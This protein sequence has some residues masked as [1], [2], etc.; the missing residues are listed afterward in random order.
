MSNGQPEQPTQRGVP[1]DSRDAKQ[2]LVSGTGGPEALRVTRQ[3]PIGDHAGHAVVANN[4]IG[5]N[6]IDV[7]HRNGFYPLPTPFVPGVEGAG[8]IESAQNLQSDQ[9]V[10]DR[11]GYI[12]MFGAYAS[13]VS[14]PTDRLIPLP[15]D[16][17]DLNAAACLLQGITTYAML[18]DVYHVQPGETILVHAAAGG[19]G[20]LMCQWASAVGATVI[21]TVSSPE[22]ATI[23][24]AN[25]C[26]YPLLNTSPQWPEEVRDLTNGRGVPVVYDSIGR[27]TFT[28]SLDCLSLRGLLVSLGQSSGPPDP[29]DVPSLGGRGSLSI[30]RPSV[31]HFVPD[32]VALLRAAEAVFA[33]IRQGRLR[34]EAKHLFPL[35]HA[36]EAHTELEARRTTGPL[37]LIP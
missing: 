2:V 20:L 13:R 12:G 25:G 21:G 26:T 4:A 31:F 5:V 11:V 37:V 16:I 17:S 28:G 32:R 15:A 10:G 1:R 36:R 14:V 22:K 34:V 7:Y 23:A 30:T 6:F 27:D 3:P 24:A 19:L 9:R 33:A 35:D 18:H 29:L 8:V